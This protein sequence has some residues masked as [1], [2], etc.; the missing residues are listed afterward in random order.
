MKEN[1][2]IALIGC[3]RWGKHILRDLKVLNCEVFVLSRSEASIQH[4]KQGNADH[5]VE[6]YSEIPSNVQGYVVAVKTA[7]HYAVIQQI[8]QQNH[9]VP[10]FCEKPLCLSSHEALSLYQEVPDLVFTMHK[11]RYHQGI[12]A[13]ARLARDNYLGKAQGIRLRRNG[14]GVPHT[15]VDCAWI[16]LPHDLSVVL[17]IFGYLPSPKY[18]QF[19]KT[20]VGIQGMRG[21][22]SSEQH[23]VSFELSE[24]NPSVERETILYFEEG[25]AV[26][27]DAYQEHIEVY[28]SGKAPLASPADPELIPFK[29]EMPLFR[30]IQAFVRFVQAEGPAPKSSVY[31][32]YQIIQTIEQLRKLAQDE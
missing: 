4:A 6:H 15:D 8:L 26:L 3:G 5:I 24:R 19:D 1:P 7:D 14:W 25:I 13:L 30:E 29:N 18:A 27:K 32:S 23:W 20:P 16:L 9:Q 11:W 10:I 12:L 17:E 31:E 28:R 21:Y 22:L 2:K